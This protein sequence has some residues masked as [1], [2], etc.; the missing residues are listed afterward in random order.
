[1]PSSLFTRVS[2]STYCTFDR[3]DVRLTDRFT[4][5]ERRAR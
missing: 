5:G 4:H 2:L 1:L 3:E